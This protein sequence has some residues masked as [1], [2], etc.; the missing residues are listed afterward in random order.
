MREVVL[1]IRHHGEPESDVSAAF[2]GVT[3]RSVSSLTGSETERKRIIEVS[4]DPDEVGAFLEQF[5]EAAPILEAEPLSPLGGSRVY[6][7]MTYDVDEWDSI[8]ERLSTMGVHY[9]VGTS[10]TGGW[11]RWTLYLDDD[12]DIGEVMDRL[13]AGGND[14]RL[15]KNVEL[16]EVTME[17]QLDASHFLAELTPRQRDALATAIALGYY[18]TDRETTVEE[19]AAEMGIAPTTAWEH[20]ARAEAKVMSEIGAHLE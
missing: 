4:G 17:P 16:S 12:D 10:I 5:R 18:G 8:S 20:L 9:R 11:E 19:I 13:A 7:A 14:V 2:P 1:R 15:T 3:L 6:V